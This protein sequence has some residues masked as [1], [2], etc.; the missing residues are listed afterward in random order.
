LNLNNSIGT[1]SGLQRV[2]TPYIPEAV[3]TASRAAHTT[4][5]APL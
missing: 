4:T 3:Q 2:R 5:M 1:D